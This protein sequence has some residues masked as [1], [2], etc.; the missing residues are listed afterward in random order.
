MGKTEIDQ[1]YHYWPF[2]VSEEDR[3]L[4]KVAE[5]IEFLE[6]IY[7]DGFDAYQDANSPTYYVGKSKFRAGSI[8]ER[9]TRNRWSLSLTEG[10]ELRL[11]ALVN[12][13]SVSG[14]AVRHWLNGFTVGEILHDINQDLVVSSKSESSYTVYDPEDEQYWPFPI[15]KEDRQKPEV[16]EKIE[17]LDNAYSDGF[18]T[19]RVCR[20]QENRYVA[21]SSSGIGYI[22]EWGGG[23]FWLL[24]MFGDEQQFTA[25][26]TD[27]GVAGLALRNWLKGRPIKSILDDI[28]RY[29]V[30]PAGFT[31][32]YTLETT[33]A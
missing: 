31:S 29:L 19:Y 12:S 6:G 10:I 27:F 11:T 20:E 33:S 22:E 26:I 8:L 15:S 1:Y 21:K 16:A 4:P 32:S 2:P 24:A 17:F 7:S 14:T 9:G 30:V 3:R 23:S 28:D 13:F 25:Y 18:E 5:K